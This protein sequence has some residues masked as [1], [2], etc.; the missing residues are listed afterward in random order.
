MTNTLN[1]IILFGRRNRGIIDSLS[2]LLQLGA[3]YG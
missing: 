1:L 3:D 2:H